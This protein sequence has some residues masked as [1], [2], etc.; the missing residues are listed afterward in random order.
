M[1][2][3][4]AQRAFE[5]FFT[6]KRGADAAGLGLVRVLSAV[7]E[8]GG[9]AALHSEPGFGTIVRI[10]LPA[11]DAPVTAVAAGPGAASETILLVE[12]EQTLR[13]LTRILL[14]RAGYIVLDAANGEEALELLERP[15]AQVALLLTD[16]GMPGI[17][18]RELAKRVRARRPGV[19]VLYSS[20]YPKDVL[21]GR[22]KIDPGVSLIEKP[23][24]EL[25]LLTAVR[26]ALRPGG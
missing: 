12:D 22:G 8:V 16:L 5:P 25:A 14:C 7:R 26:A 13:E 15:E 20:G 4:V 23:Y 3:E 9:G 2:P 10:Y 11:V 19:R 24:S 18:G 6:T 17:S 1:T 21:L